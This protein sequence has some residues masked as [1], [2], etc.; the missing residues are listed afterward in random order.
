M[1]TSGGL[2]Y[3]RTTRLPAVDGV[4]NATWF[5]TICAFRKEKIFGE[6]VDGRV[7]LSGI[8][9][10][11]AD[12]WFRSSLI[13]PEV[14]LDEWVVMPNH[15]HAI[16]YVPGAAG[17][18]GVPDALRASLRRPRRSLASLIAG[19]KASVTCRV[20]VAMG[21]QQF[22]V[23]Q[24]RYYDHGIR[25]PR[26]LQQIREYIRENPARWETDPENIRIPTP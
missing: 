2:P 3:R 4:V 23:W 17:S 7:E 25:S 26:A 12:E 16:A 24:E 19:F 9:V 20:R 11:V 1:K 15:L 18:A 8:G 14:V 13:R 22:R 6:V 5:V 21:D 10:I